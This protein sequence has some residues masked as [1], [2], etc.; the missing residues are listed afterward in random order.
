MILEFRPHRGKMR[1]PVPGQK[2]HESVD[3]LPNGMD[4][5][6]NRLSNGTDDSGRDTEADEIPKIVERCVNCD[7]STV[8]KDYSLYLVIVF[9]GPWLV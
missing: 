4:E 5:S 6:V 3:R 1:I 7:R 2:L 8:S 9:N